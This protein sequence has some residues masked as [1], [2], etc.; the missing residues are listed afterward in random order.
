MFTDM[1]QVTPRESNTLL[2][3]SMAHIVVTLIRLSFRPGVPGYMFDKEQKLYQTA[4]SGN[5]DF[6]ISKL[7]N[8]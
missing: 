8:Q 5:T 6:L 4:S 2:V 3:F 1:K 7:E